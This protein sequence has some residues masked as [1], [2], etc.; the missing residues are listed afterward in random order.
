MAILSACHT[1]IGF[2][3]LNRVMPFGRS[4]PEKI[5]YWIFAGPQSLW[6]APQVPFKLRKIWRNGTIRNSLESDICKRKMGLN[7]EF[8]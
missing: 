7:P 3:L 1:S 5:A 6:I 2:W 8:E 4:Q